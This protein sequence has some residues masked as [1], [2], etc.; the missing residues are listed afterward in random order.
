MKGAFRG[1]LDDWKFSQVEV[2]FCATSAGG[3]GPQVKLPKSC[4]KLFL[5]T[6]KVR[7]GDQRKNGAIRGRSG[8]DLNLQG[9]SPG[10]AR[11]RHLWC[12]HTCPTQVLAEDSLDMKTVRGTEN[13][14]RKF[15][16]IQGA[17]C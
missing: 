5:N 11:Q 16:G 6:A 15:C 10:D 17:R 12:C 13:V 9:A 7:Q 3:W 4:G 8:S 2:V 1:F 14:P